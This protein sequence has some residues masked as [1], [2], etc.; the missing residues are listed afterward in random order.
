MDKNASLLPFAYPKVASWTGE[1]NHDCCFW[2]GVK[3]DKE[4]GLVIAL[5]LN[6]SCLYGSINSTS[7]LF[8]LSQLRILDLTDNDF[9]HSQVPSTLG[10]L[11][12]LKYLNLE[13]S[14]FAGSIPSSI[15]FEQPPAAL[16][17]FRLKILFLDNNM[18]QGSLPFLPPSILNY[19]LP[20]NKLSGEVSPLFCNLSSI[21]YNSLGHNKLSGMLPACLKNLSNS[22]L[23]L[24]LVNNS[25]YGSTPE[26]CI[27]GSQLIVESA[28]SA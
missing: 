19:D 17:L 13:W 22:L 25:F 26:I 1:K 18:L 27:N 5:H 20:N 7:T 23:A 9:N 12:Q 16:P 3:C 21:Q 24:S 15:G 8:Q 11:S 6:S 14:G 28:S 4:S 10:N 2:D